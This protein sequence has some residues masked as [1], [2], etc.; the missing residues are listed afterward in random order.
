[1]SSNPFLEK[2]ILGSSDPWKFQS[3]NA[4]REYSASFEPEKIRRKS[5]PQGSVALRALTYLMNFMPLRNRA[6]L[7][8][9]T[10][11]RADPA[12]EPSMRREG[13]RRGPR[14]P[15]RRRPKFERD[16]KNLQ[17]ALA[18]A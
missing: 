3:S 14:S 13:A 4:A 10:R 1:M 11:E 7:Q 5:Q 6:F 12:E 15:I 16:M 17:S 9:F 8:F 2:P 18:D